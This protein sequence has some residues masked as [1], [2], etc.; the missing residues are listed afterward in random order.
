MDHANFLKLNRFYRSTSSDD[1]L[2]HLDRK[3]LLVKQ[4]IN[5]TKKRDLTI[6]DNSELHEL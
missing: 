4:I 5:K 6:T 3:V 1:T 2:I